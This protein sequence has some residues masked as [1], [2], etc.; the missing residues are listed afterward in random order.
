MRARVP[1]SGTY[2]CTVGGH[3]LRY[4]YIISHDIG[5]SL[6]GWPI[7]ATRLA[8]CLNVSGTLRTCSMDFLALTMETAYNALKLAFAE[9]DLH[10]TPYWF[11]S[12]KAHCITTNRYNV[13]PWGRSGTNSLG[14]HA[15]PHCQHYLLPPSQCQRQYYR[16][17]PE[18]P[19]I[20]RM[21]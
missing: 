17:S 5:S 14:L 16:L 2:H 9:L 6:N 7:C 19:V 20:L 13:Y 18:T 21:M 11:A 4:I 12:E 10:P 3:E 8:Q 15:L 1:L